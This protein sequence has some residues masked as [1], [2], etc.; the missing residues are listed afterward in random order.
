MTPLGHFDQ[1]RL[2]TNNLN[3]SATTH[4]QWG[5]PIDVYISDCGASP[6]EQYHNSLPFNHEIEALQA[7]QSITEVA[8][9]QGDKVWKIV[10]TRTL[11]SAHNLALDTETI[12]HLANPQLITSC[13]QLMKSIKPLGTVSPFS[14]ENGY[15]S[16]RILVN[17]INVCLLQRW[18]RLDIALRVGKRLDSNFKA[19]DFVSDMVD[20]TVG[21]KLGSLAFG[22]DCDS[23]LGWKPARDRNR[24]SPLLLQ[25]EASTLLELLWKDR[26]HFLRVMRDASLPGLSGLIF[27]AFRLVSQMGHNNSQF[28]EETPQAKLYELILRYL[29]VAPQTQGSTLKLFLKQN[30]IAGPIWKNQPAFVDPLDS[31][32]ILESFTR[33]YSKPTEWHSVERPLVL[34]VFVRASIDPQSQDLLPEVI[35]SAIDY[36]WTMILEGHANNDLLTFIQCKIDTLYLLIKPTYYSNTWKPSTRSQILDVIRKQEFLDLVARFILLLKPAA[37]THAP[38]AGSQLKLISQ[39]T[40]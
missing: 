21:E 30:I 29:L 10:D 32:M 24:F 13:I 19:A 33:Y 9:S 23:V 17:A 22:G 34:F 7:V 38:E 18:D 26:K 31:R 28:I 16:F 25:S 15:L 4:S 3:M 12:R 35:R 36:T 39:H 14:Y 2:L 1:K 8:G 5:R 27:V 20:A 37:T 40:I 11:E 6:N